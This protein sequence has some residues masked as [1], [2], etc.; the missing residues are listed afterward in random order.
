MKPL[1]FSVLPRPPD[2]TRDGLAIRNYHL[3]RALAEEFR[4]RAFALRAPHLP[5]G[6]YPDGV[7][8][9]EVAQPQRA[10]RQT[11]A[12]AESLLS[13]RAYS[14]LLYRSGPLARAL[15]R[16]ASAMKPA[17]VVAHSYHVGPAALAVGSPCWIDFHNLDSRIWARLGDTASSRASRWFARVQAPRVS[18][19][20]ARLAAC[21]AGVSCV[22][23]LEARSLSELASHAR[24]LVIPNGVD[25]SRYAFRADPAAG[26]TVF[27]VGD[28]SWPPNAE[29]IRWLRS[30]IWPLVRR[31][32]ADARAEILG[33]GAPEDLLSGASEDFRFL[34][35][36][37][38]TRPHWKG[39]AVAVVPLRA[40]GGT[41]LKILEAAASGVPVVSTSVGV[42][43][44]ALEPSKEIL[45]ADD[46]ESFAAA[47][48]QLL[49]DAGR[50]ASLAKAA[51]A[52]VEALYDWKMIGGRLP[53][54]L[55]RRAA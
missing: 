49:A 2:P 52:R 30:E 27:F 14:P 7:D 34:G 33:R 23:D 9:E 15:A 19:F 45:V 11:L 31:A 4:V 20:E 42:E 24:P 54:A 46:A 38:D 55:L 17:W 37:A 5:R 21:A 39:A 13:G 29:A 32:H 26:K 10:L 50:R 47:V 35:E 40:A 8:A 28:L 25:L 1:L 51:R 44:L 12:A 48:S 22:S 16:A 3:L 53:A 18:L 43:G 6:E 36:G 41:R